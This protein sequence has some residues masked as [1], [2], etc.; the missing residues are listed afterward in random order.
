MTPE[1]PREPPSQSPKHAWLRV[2]RESLRRALTRQRGIE[3]RWSWARLASFAAAVAVWFVSRDPIV[4]TLGLSAAGLVLFGWTI[5]RHGL[6]KTAREF[7][8]SQ[9]AVT[10]ES[11]QC[12]DGHVTLIRS[13]KTPAPPVDRCSLEP[14]LPSGPTWQLTEQELDDLDMYADPVGLF[15]LLNR[16]STVLGCRRLSDAA[17]HPLLSVDAIQRRQTAVRWVDENP[18]DRLRLMAGTHGLRRQ[19]RWLDRLVTAL[20]NVEPLPGQARLQALRWWSLLTALLMVYGLYAAGTGQFGWIL[21]LFALLAAN[22]MVYRQLRRR[23]MACLRPWRELGLVAAKYLVAVREGATDLPNDGELGALKKACAAAE[24]SGTLPGL[25]KALGWTD[26]QGA[27]HV[28]SNMIFFF[29]LHV[30]QAILRRAV[31]HRDDLLGGLSAIAEL[32][33]ITSLASF[34]WEQPIACYPEAKTEPQLSIKNGQHPLLAPGSTVPNSV[35]LDAGTRIWIVT[36][37][38]MSGKSTLLRMTGVN[39]LLAQ[40]GTTVCAQSFTFSPVRLMTDLQARDS[41]AKEES[42]FL[43]EVRHLKRMVLPP[44]GDAPVLG[45]L[46]EPLRGTNS[47][48]QVAAGIAVVEHF[49]DS[50]NLF[51][52]ATHELHITD[53]ADDRTI[54]N[55]HFQEALDDEGMVFDYQL[56]PGPAVTRNALRVLEREGYPAS[57]VKRAHD[58]LGESNETP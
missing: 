22:T 16:T 12:C 4:A 44:A 9:L 41:L 47:R 26:S 54:K 6:A 36:G 52:F 45:I 23:L 19:D 31:P 53:L 8:E 7:C 50:S 5:K 29:D 37:S 10:D 34:A 3:R 17:N 27:F 58:W 43:A 42:Y 49:R 28:A 33:V 57:V 18:A 48:E 55:F 2:H 32:E 15:G 25:I 30:A 21:A 24:G 1:P 38:N 11:L 20:T 56:R 46:D 14:I 40:M 35:S 39:I 51:L 13:N